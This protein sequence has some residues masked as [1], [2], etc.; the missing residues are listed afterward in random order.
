MVKLNYVGLGDAKAAVGTFDAMLPHV[1][2]IRAMQDRCFPMGPDDSALEI[3][4]DGLEFAAFHFTRRPLY[5]DATRLR[6]N[7]GRNYYPGLGDQE[8]ALAEFTTLKP[9]WKALRD[10]QG[11]CRPLGRDWLALNIARQGLES[12]TYYFTKRTDLYGA[13][14]HSS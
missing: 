11:F 6:R 1:L 13:K 14:P 12:A 9:Y 10:L 4:V 8:E 2:L 5:F 3:A 7:L